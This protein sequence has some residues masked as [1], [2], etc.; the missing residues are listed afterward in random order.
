MR[1]KIIAGN[2]VA[3]LIVG[4]GA[5]FYVKSELETSLGT[6]IDAEIANDQQLF[7]RSWRLSALEFVEQTRDRANTREVQ[8]AFNAL[9]ENSRRSRAFEQANN[10]AAWFQDPARGRGGMPDIVAILDETGKVIARH[11]DRNRMY[12]ESLLAAIPS[13]RRTIEGHAAHDAWWKEDENKLLQVALS[14][15]RNAEGGVIGVLLVG[16]DISNGIATRESEVLGRAV[17]IVEGERIYSSSIDQGAVAALQTE[18]FGTL[19]SNT[20]SAL[21]GTPSAPFVTDL[22]GE[23]WIGTIAPLPE[24]PSVNIA[25]AVLGNRTEQMAPAQVATVILALMG[26]GLL[27]VLVYGFVIGSSFLRPIEAI[28]EGVLTVINGRTDFRIDVESSEFG[29]LAYRIN[30]LIN[31][32]TGV[33]ETDEDGRSAGGGGWEGAAAPTQ[34][35]AGGGGGEEED[36]AVAAQLAAEDEGT[37]H[38]RIYDEY[39]AAKQAAGED[40]SNIPMDRFIARLQKN[41][42]SLTKKHGCKMVRFRVQQRGAQVILKPVIIR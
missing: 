14:P 42:A 22:G 13:I 17:V 35:S 24:T 28:E 40:V 38:Q 32:F 37:Y 9:D 27:F 41:A 21:G 4:L 10:V 29:G 30:Q 19:A 12:G 31:V 20:T 7:G 34:G 25:F 15:I 3:V 11:Q 33:A 36:A 16:Y 39:V 26:V 1:L 18:L 5:Y 2:L 8:G 6:R 23:S